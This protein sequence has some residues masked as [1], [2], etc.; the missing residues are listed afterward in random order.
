MVI[1]REE[2]EPPADFAIDRETLAYIVLKAR[3]FDTL[4]ASDDPS[5]ASNS[6]DDRSV[7]AL[8]DEADNPVQRELRVAIRQLSEEAKATLVALAWLGRGDYD[9]GEWRE[10]LATARERGEASTARYLMGLPLLGD[11][12]EDG[13]DELG[14]NLISE[15]ETGLGDPDLDTRGS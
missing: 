10:A 15:H 5:D 9:A 12:L 8:E 11:Y 2:P 14:I 1:R 4:V 3:A 7:D 13:A 6:A